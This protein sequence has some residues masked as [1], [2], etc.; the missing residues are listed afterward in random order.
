MVMIRS[1]LPGFGS[2]MEISQD[3]WALRV[4]EE[5][6]EEEE[7]NRWV[8]LGSKVN[9]LYLLKLASSW[10]KNGIGILSRG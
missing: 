4:E 10:S 1:M 3:D 2:L 9:R 6:E 7:S 5:E 8:E